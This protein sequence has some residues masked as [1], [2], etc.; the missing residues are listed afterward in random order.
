MHERRERVERVVGADVAGRALAADVLLARLQREHEAALAVASTVSP[1]RR[2]GM[3]RMSGLVTAM[4]PR[5]GPPKLMALPRRCALA[6]DDVG[7]EPA[8]APRGGR[9][10]PGRRRPRAARRRRARGLRRGGNVLEARRR[11]WAAARRR[12]RCRRRRRAASAARSV[13]APAGRSTTCGRGPCPAVSVTSTC[14]YSGC[15]PALSTIFG[16]AWSGCRPGR[17]PRPA[18]CRRRT[19]R[20]CSRPCR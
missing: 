6:D 14:R 16:R 7:A 2:P 4:K 20:R 17:T 19:S 1:T 10:T 18:P 3:R 15:T 9:A 11:S 5:P 8:R 13:T 12:R